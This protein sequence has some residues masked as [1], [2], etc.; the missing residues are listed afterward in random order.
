[1]YLTLLATCMVLQL[2]IRIAVQSAPWQGLPALVRVLVIFPLPLSAGTS[3]F[4]PLFIF[5]LKLI[6]KLTRTLVASTCVGTVVSTSSIVTVFTFNNIYKIRSNKFIML[7]DKP[8]PLT[9]SLLSLTIPITNICKQTNYPKHS[10]Q[11][12]NIACPIRTRLTNVATR[13]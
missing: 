1:M 7:N 8:W 12:R 11:W 10:Q 5:S 4:R 6:A 13:C 3:T 9:G 2:T